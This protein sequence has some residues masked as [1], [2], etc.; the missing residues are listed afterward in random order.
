MIPYIFAAFL[1]IAVLAALVVVYRR[2]G[3]IERQRH[4]THAERTEREDDWFDRI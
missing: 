1:V 2:S 3:E 4:L